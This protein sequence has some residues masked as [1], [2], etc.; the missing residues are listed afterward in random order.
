MTIKFSSLQRCAIAVLLAG[1]LTT[2]NLHADSVGAQLTARRA[3]SYVFVDFFL[4]QSNTED[5]EKRLTSGV[6]VSV[7]WALH[8]QL[9]VPMWRDAPGPSAAIRLTARPGAQGRGFVVTDVANGVFRRTFTRGSLSE[10]LSDLVS[11]QSLP[12]FPSWALQPGRGYS[13]AIRAV[14]EGGGAERI[15]TADLATTTISAENKQEISATGH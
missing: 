6:P 3:A 14:V 8:T 10:T 11:F 13:I 4:N 7:L 5:L 2:P 12:A 9:A 1:M 15:E